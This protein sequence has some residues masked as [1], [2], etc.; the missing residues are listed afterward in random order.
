MRSVPLRVLHNDYDTAV[1]LNDPV[2]NRDLDFIVNLEGGPPVKYMKWTFIDIP[3]SINNIP[4][5]DPATVN[6]LYANMYI[7]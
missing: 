7:T 6:S 5:Y 1:V 4:S 2:I 3:E